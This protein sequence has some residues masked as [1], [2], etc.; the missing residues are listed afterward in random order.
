[1]DNENEYINIDELLE[2]ENNNKILPVLTEPELLRL[3]DRIKK[4]GFIDSIDIVKRD[5]KYIILDGHH[6]IKILKKYRK[7]LK[8]NKVK[9]N[10]IDI[11]PDEEEEY[12]ISKNSDRRQLSRLLQ[13][14]IRGSQYNKM[15]NQGKRKDLIDGE[16]I[17]IKTSE[18][19]SK[20]Y[21]V[22][23]K[24]IRNN[25]KFYDACQKILE[26]TNHNF[27]FNILNGNIQSDKKTVLSLS[28]KEKNI[29]SNIEMLYNEN[30]NKFLEMDNVTLRTLIHK[31]ENIDGIEEK[32]EPV[33]N[34]E[35]KK[36][37]F[38]V[39][40]KYYKEIKKIAKDKMVNIKEVINDALRYYLEH[41]KKNK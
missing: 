14:Y 17:G 4:Y 20:K 15:K 32:K 35:W 18:I 5:C 26:N 22:S 9:Y 19:L 8:I 25:A 31:A 33:S 16:D 13:S 11:N 2:H 12:I 24:T 10:I 38:E 21:K 3:K 41:L 36:A 40:D 7:E 28:K 37:L 6:R 23:E 39:N 27:L 1:M 34:V 30:K 29:L